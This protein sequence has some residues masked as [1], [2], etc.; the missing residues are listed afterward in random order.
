MAGIFFLWPRWN[1][2]ALPQKPDI[3]QK[4]KSTIVLDKEGKELFHFGN[5]NYRWVS[6]E[7]MS[8]QLINAFIAIEDRYFYE[9][10]GLSL[11]GIFRAIW[12]NLKAG[13]IRQG[14]STLTQQLARM[15]YLDGTRT[16][17]RKWKEA[18][19]A[20]RIEKHFSKKDILEA[21]LNRVFLGNQSYGVHAACLNYFG[22]KPH[23][24]TLKEA[25]L[26]ASLPKAPT[27]LALHRHYKKAEERSKI[28]LDEMLAQGFIEKPLWQKAQKD[29]A[30]IQPKDLGAPKN[31][32]FFRQ[33]VKNRLGHLGLKKLRG[34]DIVVKT[35]FDPFLNSS[36]EKTLNLTLAD[37]LSFDVELAFIALDPSTGMVRAMMGSRDFSHSQFDRTRRLKRPADGMLLPFVYQHA[38][39]SGAHLHEVLPGQS[40]HPL[41][42]VR[43]P[44]ETQLEALGYAFG[45]MGVRRS[46]ASFP[47]KMR[48]AEAEKTLF[49]PLQ[50]ARAYGSFAAG[51]MV[52]PALYLTALK[53]D[54]SH[55]YTGKSPCETP[56]DPA[57]TFLVSYLLESKKKP[58]GLTAIFPRPFHYTRDDHNIWFVK[59]SKKLVLA[60]WLGTELGIKPLVSSRAFAESKIK[61]LDK[62]LSQLDYFNHQ[63]R[64]M[65][66]SHLTYQLREVGGEK[67]GLPVVNRD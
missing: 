13:G 47:I 31:T 41:E 4:P 8:P 40:H 66:P 46:L 59:Y 9:H 57:S 44:E 48:I 21:Y 39:A 65:P 61:E 5:K 56:L 54:R 32:A 42:L 19:L 23:Q 16:F 1:L 26:L 37:F 29:K 18:V 60:V 15:I 17:Q 28:V 43:K 52:C 3:L 49:S 50:L 22:K 33:A 12:I 63:T 10:S 67:W 62:K 14:A 25:S 27:R 7:Q 35:G 36:L 20:L 38:F 51:G 6:L 11:R 53:K 2:D 24:I 34:S 30:S 58:Q 64:I 45:L 55:I